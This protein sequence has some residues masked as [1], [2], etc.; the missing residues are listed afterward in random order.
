MS[1][2]TTR[3]PSVDLLQHLV[4]AVEDVVYVIDADGESAFWN[5]QL[6]ETT[7]YTT[8]EIAE[9]EPKQF[10]PPEQREHTPG[11]GDAIAALGDSQ[12]VLD[13]VGKS[14]E[15]IPH[16]CRG[17]TIEDPE[18]GELYRCGIARDVSERQARERELE[19]QRDELATLARIADLLLAIS[20]DLVGADSRD[21]VERTLCDRLAA[22]DLYGPAWIGARAYE[23]EGILARVCAGTDGHV[24]TGAELK[25]PMGLVTAALRTGE[26]QVGASDDVAIPAWRAAVGAAEAERVAVVPLTNEGGV[27]GVLALASARP[28]AFGDRER[29]AIQALGDTVSFVV[30]AIRRRDLL[31]AEAVVELRFGMESTEDALSRT[32]GALDCEFELAGSVVMADTWLVYLAVEGASPGAVVE[33]LEGADAVDRARVVADAGNRRRIEVHLR[34][35]PLWRAAAAV[36]GTIRSAT[37]DGARTRFALELPETAD[38]RD[39]VAQVQAVVPAATLLAQ[40][41][42]ERRP[43]TGGAPD[44]VL[45]RLTDRQREVLTAAYQAGFFEW[46]RDSTGEEVAAALDVTAPTLHAHLRK[47]QQAVLAGLLEHTVD[48]SAV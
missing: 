3:E 37:V 5:E 43:T 9:M 15:R 1:E 11:L 31:L 21:A 34:A 33:H 39:A 30:N 24:E 35:S 40:S 14:G 18:S 25:P 17:T 36:G 26:I 20:R 46:P 12:V 32:A 29:A 23:G 10:L 47:A 22:S 44:G 45:A 4:H 2:A 8:A 19:R 42:R 7:G 6:E 13:L 38:V 27:S 41:E 28:T 16:E 48:E